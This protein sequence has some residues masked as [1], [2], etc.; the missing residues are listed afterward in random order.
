MMQLCFALILLCEIAVA[1]T[2]MSLSYPIYLSFLRFK[3]IW[4]D[5]DAS[6]WRTD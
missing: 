6:V 4:G 3:V 5:L 2:D 1:V